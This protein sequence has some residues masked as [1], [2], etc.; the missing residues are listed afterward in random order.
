MRTA[1]GVFEC[2]DLSLQRGG[3]LKGARHVKYAQPT[4]PNDPPGWT[5]DGR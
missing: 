1:E 5:T 2:G 4:P 3:T